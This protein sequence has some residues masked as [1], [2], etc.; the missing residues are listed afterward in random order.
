M[1]NELMR[2]LRL[3]L[4]PCGPS[5]IIQLA[6]TQLILVDYVP[7]LESHPGSIDNFST[8]KHVKQNYLSGLVSDGCK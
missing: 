8:W 4:G 5:M 6:T 1:I 2:I 3:T 7:S